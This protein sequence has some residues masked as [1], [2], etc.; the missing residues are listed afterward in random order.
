L[1]GREPI[2]SKQIQ[3]R[4]PLF[5]FD[6]LLDA[7]VLGLLL[8]CFYA[9]VSVG[10]SVAFGLLD[11]PHIAHPAFVV[12]GSYGT[13]LLARYGW[14]PIVAGVALMPLFFLIGVLVYR[15]YYETFEKRGSDAGVRG[16]AF[17]FG[18]A[19]II[20]VGL[21]L[22]F[23]V[24]QRM[25]EAKYIGTSLALGD[26][27]L[28][29]R[30]LVAFGVALVLTGSLAL[31]LSRTFTGRAIK[32]VAQD[33]PALRLMGANPVRIKQW[34]FGIATGV[35]ALAGALL[36]IVGPV[37]PSMDRAYIGRTFCVVVLAGLGSM[38][39]TLAAGLILGVSESIVL[40]LLG[41]S[42][43]PAVSFGLLLIV[44]GIRP[45]GLFGR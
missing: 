4:R 40:T 24:D 16:L 20:E 27:R 5:S 34:A 7:V 39:G 45:Q 22:A 44:L 26:M 33:E 19:F 36:I 31:Y 23:G 8:G 32:A 10:L 28:P 15:F 41:A 29:W 9:A 3:I 13:W 12:L 18:V 21:I 6:L 11:V 37:E 2:R 25:V 17:F 42:W 35:T 30:M 43:A 1:K 14:D 38:S